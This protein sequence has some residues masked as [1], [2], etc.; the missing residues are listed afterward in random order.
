MYFL[1]LMQGGIVCAIYLFILRHKKIPSIVKLIVIVAY[2]TIPIAILVKGIASAIYISDLIA[3]ILII[4]FLRR[5]QLFNNLLANKYFITLSALLIFAPFLSGAILIIIGKYLFSSRD[6][7]DNVIWFY[8][9]F[10]YLLVFGVGL[11][12]RLDRGQIKEFIEINICYGVLLAILGLVN[13]YGPFNMAIFETIESSGMPL[14]SSQSRIGLGFLGLFR[15]SVGQWFSML[16]LLTIGAYHFIS[17][18]YRIIS[19]LMIIAGIGVTLL[20]HSRSGFFGLVAGIGVLGFSKIKLRRKII[21]FLAFFVIVLWF[22]VKGEDFSRR[23]FPKSSSVQLQSIDYSDDP[24]AAARVSARKESFRYFSEHFGGLLLGIGPANRYG[25]YEITGLYGAHNE[26]MDVIYRSGILGSI[27][28]YVFLLMLFKFFVKCLQLETG[29]T[30][31]S[32]IWSFIAIIAANVVMAFTQAHLLH[33]YAT[34]T[35]GFYLY[36]L[37]GVFLG[38]HWEENVMK[39]S[40]S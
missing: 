4:Y 11:S 38:S 31:R 25:V 24:A 23:F 33:D 2:V 37:Y 34:Y 27:L 35:F 14:R 3:P 26:Y 12:L 10:T 9:N 40:N 17:P 28:L 30:F 7:M 39:F 19:L 8:R 29:R 1:L 22:N 36:L 18:K 21:V 20:S 15:G 32:L 16:V 13:Y 5:L 6:L